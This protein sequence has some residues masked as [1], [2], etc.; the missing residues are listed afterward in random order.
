[1]KCFSILFSSLFFVFLAKNSVAELATVKVDELLMADDELTLRYSAAG[2][3]RTLT[4]F[5][6]TQENSDYETPEEWQY[7]AI[8]E[9]IARASSILN[10]LVTE[11]TRQS[12]ANVDVNI[13]KA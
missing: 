7:T 3:A 11:T 9:S 12:Q 4:Y 8:R 5:I 1:M 10:V 6:N 2:A 13:H